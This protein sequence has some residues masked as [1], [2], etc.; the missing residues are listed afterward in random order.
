MAR[1]SGLNFGESIPDMAFPLDN[2]KMLARQPNNVY[3]YFIKLV[4]TSFETLSREIINT[5]QFSVH[6]FSRSLGPANTPIARGY[7]GIYFIFDFSPL[8]VQYRYA[9]EPFLR[10]LVEL[11]AILGGTFTMLGLVE[12]F[13]FSAL[14]GKPDGAYKHQ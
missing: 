3:Q 8:E 10:F 5:N 1:G 14:G 6:T 7:P 11:C 12:R 2:R 13:C 4:P 9:Q